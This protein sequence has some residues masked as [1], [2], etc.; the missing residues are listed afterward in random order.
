[1]IVRDSVVLPQPDSPT[2]PSVS[3]ALID[4]STPS[5]AWICPTVRFRDARADREV[6]DE[7]LDAQDL[8]ALTG[9]LMDRLG[10]RCC[11][12]F[13]RSRALPGDTAS[14][15]FDAWP[16]SSSAKW[17]AA[18]CSP[19]LD[20]RSAG[21]SSR[22]AAPALREEA[23]RMERAAGRQVDQRRRLRPGSVAA[24]PR[25]RSASAGRP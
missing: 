13:A 7:V 25:P 12:R 15:N 10:S 20:R 22:H 2:S 18:T 9:A 5:T 16:T 14:A 3:P 1:M 6:L 19:G 23:A 21:T 17:Q 4:R 24:T 8:L 11:V